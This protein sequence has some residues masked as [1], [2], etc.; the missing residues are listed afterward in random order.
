MEP[1]KRALVKEFYANLGKIRSFTYY[2]K[3]RWVPFGERAI[4]QQFGLREG[5]D[6]TEY[7]QLQNIPNLEEIAKELTYGQGEWQRTKTISNAFINIV[8]LTEVSKFWFYF[9]NSV[10]KPSK[11]VLIVRQDRTILLYPFVKGFELNVGRIIEESI[12][13]CAENKFSGNIP[14]PSLITH[15]CIKGGVKFNEVEERCPKASPLTLASALILRADS[16][17]PHY[18]SSNTNSS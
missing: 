4:S 8:D 13:D 9:V 15:L 5:G 16:D 7:E 10:L 1:G 12:M 2:I 6:C 14:H 18:R 17:L 11:H 3:G